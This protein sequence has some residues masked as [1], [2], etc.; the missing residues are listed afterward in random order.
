VCLVAVGT[1]AALLLQQ[2]FDPFTQDIPLC[3][4]CGATR[5]IHALV[6]GNLLQALRSN[7]MIIL[8]LPY[9]AVLL[10]D[11]TRSRV[12]GTPMRT[13]PGNRVVIGLAL[14]ALVFGIIRNLPA[15]WFLQPVSYVAP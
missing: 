3:P 5:A 7:V 2:V 8:L 11:W 6:D 14:V 10:G 15:L 4:G 1:G 13:L 12:T 9:T